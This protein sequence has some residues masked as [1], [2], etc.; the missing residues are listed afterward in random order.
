M[1]SAAAGRAAWAAAQGRGRVA[2]AVE[3]DADLPAGADAHG[4]PGRL[5]PDRASRTS[6]P[7]GKATIASRPAAVCT[8]TRT[9]PVALPDAGAGI[10]VA[11]DL[12]GGRAGLA[13]PVRAVLGHADAVAEPPPVDD[14]HGDGGG[15]GAGPATETRQTST[16]RRSSRRIRPS[17]PV[18]SADFQSDAARRVR[19]D[20]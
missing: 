15:G 7:L 14:Q 2:G 16:A 18:G 1:S 13:H 8:A 20:E 17:C 10:E 9:E 6:P 11:E 3:A 4:E 12:V 19:G 5:R